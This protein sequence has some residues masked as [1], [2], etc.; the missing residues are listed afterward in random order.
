MKTLDEQIKEDEELL[1]QESEEKLKAQ[2]PEPDPEVEEP[3]EEEV[4]EEP[5]TPE[6]PAEDKAE[7]K[8]DKTAQAVAQ[9]AWELREAKRQLAE[10]NKPKEVKEEKP[11]AEVPDPEAEPIAH[12][13]HQIAETKKQ[14][15]ELA[16]WRKQQEETLEQ[17]RFV[18]AQRSGFQAAESAFRTTVPDYTEVA[19]HMVSS[20]RNSARLLSPQATD[21]QISNFVE[22]Q[23]L[24]WAEQAA[25]QGKQPAQA[26]YEMSKSHFGF[27]RKAAP[28]E[29]KETK[30]NLE[31]IEKNRRKSATGLNTGQ[32]SKK[33]LTLKDVENMSIAEMECMD[34]GEL[35]ELLS[36]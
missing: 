7:I 25:Q 11:K 8:E 15:E 21:Q 24:T 23:I 27:V 5:S 16:Q 22:N 19:N 20:M 6:E 28:V 17:E 10:L 35:E 1:R 31:V 34:P 12:L 30:P 18:N 26:L 9:L 14:A 29:V 3:E 32:T 33:G 2:D 36:A 4:I 13:Q